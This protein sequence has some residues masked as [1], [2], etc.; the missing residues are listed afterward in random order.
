MARTKKPDGNKKGS[1]GKNHNG[2]RRSFG[3]EDVSK[4]A[5]RTKKKVTVQTSHTKLTVEQQTARKQRRAEA[6]SERH[7]RLG[8]LVAAA[9][10]TLHDILRRDIGALIAFE[11]EAGKVVVEVIEGGPRRVP[12]ITVVETN[13]PSLRG[14]NKE[15]YVPISGLFISEFRQILSNRLDYERQLALIEI[16]KPPVL[17]L[18]H[19]RR[20]AEQE[21]HQQAA[22]EI[23]SLSGVER[24]EAPIASQLAPKPV[25]RELPELG[26][27]E[28]MRID[29][30]TNL[31]YWTSPKLLVHRDGSGTAAYFERRFEAGAPKFVLMAVEAG[32]SLEALLEEHVEIRMDFGEI[33]KPNAEALTIRDLHDVREARKYVA[34]YLREQLKEMGL[35]IKV[36]GALVTK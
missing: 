7:A 21:L 13:V 35:R 9:D 31:L 33:F 29:H 22:M 6:A 34:S 11:T 5:V 4:G 16:V 27:A 28:V 14:W 8:A 12:A 25:S 2:V 3:T 15:I 24:H 36:P 17:R 1:G 10:G 26:A 32:H 20:L 19:E 30:F 18:E 23:V